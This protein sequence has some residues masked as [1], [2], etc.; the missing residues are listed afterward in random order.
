MLIQITLPEMYEADSIKDVEENY[1]KLIGSLVLIKDFG[2]K[3]VV[4][5]VCPIDKKGSHRM[6]EIYCGVKNWEN[7]KTVAD[8]L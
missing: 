3:E 5:A 1:Q 6:I 7:M 4:F 2:S 8:K